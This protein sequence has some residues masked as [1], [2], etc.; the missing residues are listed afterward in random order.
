MLATTLAVVTTAAL[1]LLFPETRWIGVLGTG[2]LAYLH[3]LSLLV[4]ASVAGVVAA[5]VFHLRRR[6][7]NEHAE[8]NPRSD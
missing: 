3:P 1:C 6:S 5:F 8:Q 7:L 4:V 2:L